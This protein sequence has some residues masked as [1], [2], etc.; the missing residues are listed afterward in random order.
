ML[1]RLFTWRGMVWVWVGMVGS[2]LRERSMACWEYDDKFEEDLRSIGR[3]VAA[4]NM[5]STCSHIHHHRTRW[6]DYHLR[7][8]NPPKI[9]SS[10]NVVPDRDKNFCSPLIL[11]CKSAKPESSSADSLRDYY[12]TQRVLGVI[13]VHAGI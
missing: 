6:Q 7:P 11:P 10:V 1:V 8:K 5:P 4:T 13:V 2:C 3:W 12:V 9:V